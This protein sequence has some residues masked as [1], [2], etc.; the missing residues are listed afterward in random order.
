MFGNSMMGMNAIPHYDHPLDTN[1]YL[2][3][4]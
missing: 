1:P 4:M 2:P 3:G